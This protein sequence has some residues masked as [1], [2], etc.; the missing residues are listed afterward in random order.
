MVSTVWCFP[1]DIFFFFLCY[2]FQCIYDIHPFTVFRLW[3]TF[4]IKAKYLHTYHVSYLIEIIWWRWQNIANN[5]KD[6]CT[7]RYL[8][9]SWNFRYLINRSYETV[10]SSMI[11][12]FSCRVFL[13][14][15][16]VSTYLVIW[17]IS[18]NFVL[19]LVLCGF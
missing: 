3:H 19:P 12:D 4:V 10:S 1:I 8:L 9:S 17:L 5:L 18:P 7:F 6:T 2:W 16:L 11:L 14:G 15:Y 13:N